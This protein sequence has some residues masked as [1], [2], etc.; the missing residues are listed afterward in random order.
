MRRCMQWDMQAAREAVPL[1][2]TRSSWQR[3][4]CSAPLLAACPTCRPH[5]GA[6]TVAPT[7]RPCTLAP[8]APPAHTNPPTSRTP[9]WRQQR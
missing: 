5:G 3:W 2:P 1:R 4:Y 8:H 6:R 7:V 9:P